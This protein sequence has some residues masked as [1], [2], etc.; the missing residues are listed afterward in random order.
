MSILHMAGRPVNNYIPQESPKKTPFM[1][2][3]RTQDHVVERNTSITKKSTGGC[4]L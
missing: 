3:I 4:L 1:E 2:A